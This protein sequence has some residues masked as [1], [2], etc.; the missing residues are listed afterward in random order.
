[1]RIPILRFV[2]TVTCLV[3]CWA[4]YQAVGSSFEFV[5][6]DA[7]GA[8]YTQ[9]YG[10]NDSGQIVGQYSAPGISN[11][12]FLLS[13]NSFTLFQIPGALSTVPLGINDSGQIVGYYS[14]ATG[15]GHGFLA[16]N[17]ISNVPE[18][19]SFLLL[20]TGRRHASSL[21]TEAARPLNR[22]SLLIRRPGAPS[23]L[24]MTSPSA[25]KSRSRLTAATS[26]GAPLE[27]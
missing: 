17:V 24:P 5:I 12:G 7:P 4:P 9:A 22:L 11:L 10:I 2:T 6:I 1:M 27:T 16:T 19:S 25:K 26:T 18:P 20:G 23:T 15:I 14:D 21:A 3:L 13:G 8:S